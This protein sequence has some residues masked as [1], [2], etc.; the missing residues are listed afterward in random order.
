[1]TD[2]EEL[3]DQYLMAAKENVKGA[4]KTLDPSPRDPLATALLRVLDTI[5]AARKKLK[6][7]F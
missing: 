4:I 7:R 6:H 3:A 2:E 5:D 1:M